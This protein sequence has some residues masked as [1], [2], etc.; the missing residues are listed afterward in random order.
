MVVEETQPEPIAPEVIAS[1]PVKPKRVYNKKRIATA[2]VDQEPAAKI[3]KENTEPEAPAGR[4]L[5]RAQR[6]KM[7]QKI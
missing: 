7:N 6:A 2:A 3:Q 5:T 1:E 4:V